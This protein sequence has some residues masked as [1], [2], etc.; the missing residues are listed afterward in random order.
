MSTDLL[1]SVYDIR[2]ALKLVQ[3][4]PDLLLSGRNWLGMSIRSRDWRLSN[5]FLAAL[6]LLPGL[7]WHLE[8]ASNLGHLPDTEP[9]SLESC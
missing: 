8:L 5:S 7:V 6:L 3:H 4:S 9:G 2:S 1:C